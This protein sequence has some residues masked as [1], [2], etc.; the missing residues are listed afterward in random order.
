VNL[1]RIECPDRSRRSDEGR[2]ADGLAGD[3][4]ALGLR[5]TIREG[6]KADEDLLRKGR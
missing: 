5:A 6:I 1:E 3:G 4:F 2:P